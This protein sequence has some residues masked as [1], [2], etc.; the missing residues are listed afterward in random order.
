VQTAARRYQCA[1]RVSQPDQRDRQGW[2][3]ADAPGGPTKAEPGAGSA[4][5]SY[6][7]G[8]GNGSDPGLPNVPS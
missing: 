2:D 4:L 5:I 7:A 3:G 6:T 1:Q 8:F